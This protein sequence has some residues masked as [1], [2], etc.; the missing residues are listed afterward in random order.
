MNFELK[1]K[2]ISLETYLLTSEIEDINIINNLKKDIESMNFDTKK[3]TS[4]KASFSG[5]NSLN[6]NK[7]FHSFLKLIKP[8]MKTI[9]KGDFFIHESWANICS[10]QEE[11]TE[12]NHRGVTAFCGVLYLTEGGPGTYFSDLNYTVEEKVGR[13]VLFHPYLNHKVIKLNNDLKR[14]T[15]A[16]N[17]NELSPWLK[18][19]NNI[20]V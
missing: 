16:F 3:E 5:W 20:K 11:V 1:V 8:Q 17:M 4:V 18:S 7:N 6:N 13:F 2:D 10:N 9:Y 15:V 19:N 14:I 12:H